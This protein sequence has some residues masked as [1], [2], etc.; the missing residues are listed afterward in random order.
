MYGSIE[1]ARSIAHDPHRVYFRPLSCY[2]NST[3]NVDETSQARGTS[4]PR[5]NALLNTALSLSLFHLSFSVFLNFLVLVRIISSLISFSS[6]CFFHFLS[7]SLSFSRSFVLVPLF[8]VVFFSFFFRSLVLLL[9]SSPLS[10]R[11]ARSSVLPLITGRGRRAS[12]RNPVRTVVVPCGRTWII[13][14]CYRDTECTGWWAGLETTTTVRHRHGSWG[15]CWFRRKGEPVRPIGKGRFLSDERIFDLYLLVYPFF[16]LSSFIH[17]ILSSVIIIVII[18]ISQHRIFTLYSSTSI[19]LD[20]FCA[21]STSVFG[22]RLERLWLL[23]M[24][25]FSRTPVNLESCGD[26]SFL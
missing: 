17:S 14:G 4:Y 22:S 25:R 18:I 15:G 10:P 5:A 1:H 21:R 9:A 2:R 13:V 19:A 3:G 26:W 11:F 12:K 16:L 8:I 6:L 20:P 24:F 23:T 7:L